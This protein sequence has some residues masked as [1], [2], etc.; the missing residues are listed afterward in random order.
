MGPNTPQIVKM[1][2]KSRNAEE[3]ALF[4]TLLGKYI[5]LDIISYIIITLLTWGLE[6]VD[7]VS[8]SHYT[9]VLTTKYV[10]MG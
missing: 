8:V 10:R 4:I 3:S 1:G 9:A 5:L 2:P 7:S 6:E